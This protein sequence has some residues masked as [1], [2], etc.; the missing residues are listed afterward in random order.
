MQTAF[1]LVGY[2]KANEMQGVIIHIPQHKAADVLAIVHAKVDDPDVGFGDWELT[3]EQAQQIGLLIG[4]PLDGP[5]LRLYDYFLEPQV[6]T[7]EM[8]KL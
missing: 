4:A 5:F 3:P 6:F 2:V 1:R 7:S 8:A